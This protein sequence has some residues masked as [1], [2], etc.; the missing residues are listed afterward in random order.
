MRLFAE[1]KRN[2]TMDLLMTSPISAGEIVTG[3]FLA[4][5]FI[6]WTIL[7]TLAV[8]PLT[9]RFFSSFDKGPVLTSFLGIGLMSAVYVAIGIFASSLSAG[10]RFDRLFRGVRHFAV[11]L[12]HRLGGG[13]C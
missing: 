11:F 10:K 12:G 8:Y 5:V 4:G 1:E 3:K 6:V 13:Q 7:A 2:R 9:V